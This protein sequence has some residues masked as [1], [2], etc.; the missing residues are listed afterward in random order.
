M[1]YRIL[2]PLYLV[3]PHE[4]PGCAA[5]FNSSNFAYKH[6]R[7]PYG[8]PPGCDYMVDLISPV[9]LPCSLDLLKTMLRR[10][11]GQSFYYKD[12]EAGPNGT[13]YSYSSGLGTI[14]GR[15][16]ISNDNPSGRYIGWDDSGNI[17]EMYYENNALIKKKLKLIG[18]SFSGYF[19]VSIKFPD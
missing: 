8:Y 7:Y 4:E 3:S 14:T 18:G 5:I 6:Y 17:V 11:A 12:T 16:L 9:P 2:K 19:D 10:D 1:P 13:W 15:Y